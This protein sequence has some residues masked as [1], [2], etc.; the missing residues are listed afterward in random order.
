M[1]LGLDGRL[2]LDLSVESLSELGRRCD[3][4]LARKSFLPSAWEFLVHPLSLGCSFTL[5]R[6]V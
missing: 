5:L 6:A 1:V 3:L 4:P 2:S